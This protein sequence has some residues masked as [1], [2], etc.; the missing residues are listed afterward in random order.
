MAEAN[1]DFDEIDNED[2]TNEV[3][4][5]TDTD[6]TRAEPTPQDKT[7]ASKLTA[8]AQAHHDLMTAQMKDPDNATDP[9]DQ[10]MMAHIQG[11]GKLIGKAQ[12][13][14]AADGA[15]DIPSGTLGGPDGTIGN[16]STGD[17][18]VA[19][20]GTGVAS[21]SAET[22]IEV[23]V[24]TAPRKRMTT[25]EL[26]RG[27]QRDIELARIERARREREKRNKS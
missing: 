20:D 4:A 26:R 25:E 12:A 13:T 22:E 10:E 23:V 9:A 17:G 19:N 7:V 3:V 16:S 24:V 11:I 5:P 1:D 2:R 21:R 15:S 6:E 8:L 18:E 27:A 14:Q